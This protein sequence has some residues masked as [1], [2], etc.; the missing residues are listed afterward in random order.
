MAKEKKIRH[1]TTIAGALCLAIVLPLIVAPWAVLTPIIFAL[2]NLAFYVTFIIDAVQRSLPAQ[3]HPILNIIGIFATI[4]GLAFII[5]KAMPS[6]EPKG[7]H[8]HRDAS[9][10]EISDV[11]FLTILSIPAAIITVSWMSMIMF[12]LLSRK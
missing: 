7:G 5:F 2:L 12:G 1:F 6:K 9:S 3:I 8:A 10:D 11:K 4:F